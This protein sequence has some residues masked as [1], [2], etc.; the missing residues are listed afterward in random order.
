MGLDFGALKPEINSAR[1]Y[2]G[3]GSTSLM[4]AA[5]AWRAL[6][7]ELNSAAL[8]YQN[9]VNQLSEGWL[10]Q[11][12]TAMAQ[13]VAPYVTWMKTTALQAEQAGM[14]ASNA[15]AAYESALS[16][17]VPPPLI[18]ANRAELAQAVNTNVFG[19]NTGVI[20]QLETRY[21]EMWAQDA[22][23]MY[24]Y[25]GQSSL[26]TQVTPFPSAP[27]MTTPTAQAT[28]NATVGAVTGNAA[29]GNAQSTVSQAITQTPTTLSSLASP[30]TTTTSATTAAAA[31]PPTPIGQELWFL[32][33][34]QTIL[35]SNLA[36]FVNGLSPFAGFAY[37]T[38]GLPYFSVGMGNFGTQIAKSMGWLGGGAPA[39]AGAL[40]GLGGLGGLLGGG[41]GGQIAAG[42]GNAA[43]VGPL[44]VPPVWSGAAAAAPALGNAPLPISS[45][46]AAPE[47]GGAGNLLG[48]MP[49]AGVGGGIPGG[50][51]PRYGFR[52]TVMT[53]PPFAG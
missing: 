39:A 46:S 43:S 2:A 22:T 53:R 29:A 31:D 15:A 7:A 5:S 45:V 41:G 4:T 18:A 44:S 52:P 32:L 26:A 8:G 6:A 47:A 20:A 24:N 40:P 3:P 9:V 36:S 48:G 1:M 28:Q 19:Q 21:G 51:G 42:L 12:S 11:A 10:G 25:A 49:L 17:V 35:P 27:Q 38:E 50:T 37:N 33:T 13:A 23:T 14:Q 30:A 16:S 34:G